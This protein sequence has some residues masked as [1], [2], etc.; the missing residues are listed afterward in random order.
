MSDSKTKKKKNKLEKK[1]IYTELK[2]RN[3]M[4]AFYCLEM[5]LNYYKQ[6]LKRA[7]EKLEWYKPEEKTPEM[8]EGLKVIE[9][10]LCLRSRESGKLFV[11]VGIF[12]ID[13]D[14]YQYPDKIGEAFTKVTDGVYCWKYRPE[15][16]EEM[17]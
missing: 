13:G 7:Q 3:W 17:I 15:L 12:T 16:P 9:V 8:K 10:D 1:L 2:L 11:N 5:A 6:S 4:N 14:F